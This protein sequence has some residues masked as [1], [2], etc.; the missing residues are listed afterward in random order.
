MAA[1]S[2]A[3]TSSARDW[4]LPECRLRSDLYGLLTIE[5]PS[6]ATGFCGS[7]DDSYYE[8]VA[9]LLDGLAAQRRYREGEESLV[10]Y[11]AYRTQRL[12]R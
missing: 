11:L 9:D 4:M 3:F 10:D 1:Q 6:P 8:E 12:S 7:V 2:T 5:P